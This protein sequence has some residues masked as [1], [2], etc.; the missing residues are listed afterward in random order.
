MNAKGSE[1]H[2]IIATIL[3]LEFNY[4]QESIAT[5]MKVSQSTI[6][7]WI[8]YGKLILKNKALEKE[9]NSI[10]V[11]LNNLGYYPQKQLENNIIDII[12]TDN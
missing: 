8:K 3:H 9:I 10:K 1:K 5:L 12:P 6:S 11:E 2:Q 7:S 4:S